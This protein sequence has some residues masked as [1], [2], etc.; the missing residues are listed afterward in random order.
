MEGQGPHN[1]SGAHSIRTNMI[2]A[3]PD[4]VATDAVG[5]TVM[6]FN[7][8][9]IEHLRRSAAKGHGTLDMRHITVSG[10]PIDKVQMGYR[11]P[12]RSGTGV[13]F[14]YGRSN[15][16]WL[17]HGTHD[18][19]TL[20]E[21]V[22]GG[23][24]DATPFE[25]VVDNGQVWTRMVS[26]TYNETM[27]LKSFFY[28]RYGVYTADVVAYA[29]TYIHSDREQEGQLWVGADDGVKVW[30]NGEVVVDEPESGRH[31][32][33]EHRV[34]IRLRAGENRV[35]LKVRNEVG[36]YIFSLMATDGDGDTMPGIE[37]RAE[38][39]AATLV[40][41]S[42][43]DAATPSRFALEQNYPNPF[44]GST[45]IRFALPEPAEVELAVYN[46]TGQKVAA[47]AQ[48]N[49]PAGTYTFRWHGRDGQGRDLASGV[50]LY[51]LRAGDRV[52]TRRLLLLR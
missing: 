10:D 40:E 41:E 16:V 6:G 23:E 44:N 36:D 34:P 47:L 48:E 39:A 27:D 8:W 49:R 45:V 9:D 4:P 17:I 43:G 38:P 5:A 18:G 28:D 29:F 20:E 2:I 30:L 35:L 3:G 12:A 25:G 15:M 33:A 21:D 26:N 32:L 46:T 1:N 52:S 37:H 50:Y 14:Y 24:A 13:R 51:R 11:K 19:A 42:A 7:P 31:M 22:L